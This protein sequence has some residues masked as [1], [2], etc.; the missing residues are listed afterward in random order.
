MHDLK[1]R[2]DMMD[3]KLDVDPKSETQKALDILDTARG[4]VIDPSES[5]SLLRKLDLRLLPILYITYALQS[6]DRT[7]LNYAAVFGIQDDIGLSG[8]EFSWAGALLYLGYLVW[9]FPTNILLQKLPINHV[10][11]ATVILWGISVMCHAAS[12][13]F[14]GLAAA[15]VFLGAFEASI[16]PGTMLYFS[17]YYQRREQP[18]RM[19]AW[20]GSA[21]LGYIIAGITTFGIAHI[22]GSL[23]SWR[24]LFLFWGAITIVWG[25]IMIF[26]LPGSPLKTKFLTEREREVAIDRIKGNGTGVEDK[27]FKWY[28]F[29]EAVLDLKTWLLFVFA[30]ASN[31]PNG[32][33]T[34]FQGLVIRGMGFS[35]LRT[36]LIQMP[37]GAV[38]FVL[39]PIVC[40]FASYYPNAR[41]TIMLLCLIPFL[42]GTLGLWLIDQSNPYGRLAC[43]WISFAY[44][45]AWSLAMSVATANTA[46]HTKKI[47]TNAI[48]IIGYCLGNF[49]GPFFFKANQAPTYNL[50][51]AMMLFCVG[52]QI[53]CLVSLWLLLWAR[54][55]SRRVEHENSPENEVQAQERGFADETDLQNKYF[56][57][58]Y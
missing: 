10:M 23:A 6:I 14:A 55:R 48:L 1:S 34:T 33:L 35:Q 15:R 40:F 58:V 36:T 4:D 12:N 42:G 28:Q 13:N 24:L 31:C 20:I 32:G 43:L 38:Q 7:T 37:S 50:G 39:C 45:A 27:T 11:S 26:I 8:T 19:G 51:V 3:S 22:K 30:V 25:V 47:T 21:G 41:I 46:G 2:E 29:R 56:K 16:N 54:N 52:L 18:L 49:A 17:M 44:T 57:Y 9:E 53:A 5:P